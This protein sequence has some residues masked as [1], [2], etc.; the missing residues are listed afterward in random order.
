MFK[1]TKLVVNP[2]HVG[3]CDHF[4]DTLV[5]S[6]DVKIEALGQVF[7]Q[8]Y[9]DDNGIES[10]EVYV[11]DAHEVD[12][13]VV[14]DAYAARS[15]GNDVTEFYQIKKVEESRLVDIRVRPMGTTMDGALFVLST[16]EKT[17]ILDERTHFVLFLGDEVFCAETDWIGEV[18]E[19][20]GLILKHACEARQ[21]PESTTGVGIWLHLHS[22]EKQKDLVLLL[23]TKKVDG[24]ERVF[25][26]LANDVLFEAT[27]RTRSVEVEIESVK[28]KSTDPEV[29]VFG[30]GIRRLAHPFDVRSLTAPGQEVVL[31]AVDSAS[32]NAWQTH[33]DS[34]W[35]RSEFLAEDGLQEEEI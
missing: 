10:D 17:E 28:P 16:H 31:V 2:N 13:D 9:R 34:D 29:T 33:T 8:Q 5:F 25:E 14:I 18:L 1:V 20:Q 32:S 26:G 30:L 6:D 35:E 19:E 11:M 15:H 24:E 22:P 23:R 27:E 12:D 7:S 3:E 21:D 4:S